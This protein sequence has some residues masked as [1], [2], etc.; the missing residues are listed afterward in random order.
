MKQLRDEDFVILEQLWVNNRPELLQ[1]VNKEIID[2]FRK[3][4]GLLNV[5][6]STQNVEAKKVKDY[7]EKILLK[8]CLLV[9]KVNIYP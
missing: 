5:L 6:D 9:M 2:D 1:N 8:K 4:N 7:A 3:V